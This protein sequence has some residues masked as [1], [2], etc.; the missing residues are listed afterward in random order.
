MAQASAANPNASGDGEATV[1]WGLIR[2]EKSE[3]V[4]QTIGD[5]RSNYGAAWDIPEGTNAFVDDQQVDDSYILKGDDH[6]EFV[7][8]MGEKG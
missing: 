4:G 8:K 3:F 1:V 2:K 6:L 5:I 7:R